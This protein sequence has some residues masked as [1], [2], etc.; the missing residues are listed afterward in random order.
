MQAHFELQETILDQAEVEILYI[1]WQ[2]SEKDRFSGHVAF[3]GG[4]LE[5][6]ESEISGVI[7]EVQEEVGIDLLD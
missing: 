4:H 7:W 6:G 3:P 1:L 2:T 5:K